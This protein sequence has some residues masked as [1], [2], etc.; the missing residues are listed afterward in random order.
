MVTSAMDIDSTV[1]LPANK[2][3]PHQWQLGQVL[4]CTN[5]DLI[6]SNGANGDSMDTDTE[7]VTHEIS[8]LAYSN[9]GE[10]V[11]AGDTLGG[12][13]VYNCSAK[14]LNRIYRRHTA[15]QSHN[16]EFDYL[17]SLEIEER[18]NH[19]TWL[20]RPN[21]SQFLLTTNDKTIK[22]W[23]IHP[24]NK[25]DRS[26][27]A[28]S[29]THSD[30][31]TT[32]KKV[33]ANAHA[34]HINSLS[35]CSDGESF[36][37]SDDLR[38]NVCMCFIMNFKFIFFFVPNFVLNIFYTC[39]TCVDMKPTDMESLSEVLT[40]AT[41]HPSQSHIFAYST[42]TGSVRLADMRTA[43]LCDNSVKEFKDASAKSSHAFFAEIL[44]CISDIKFTNAGH[45]LLMRDYMYKILYLT[46]N[47]NIFSQY[48]SLKLW[49]A[50]M[51]H[52]PVL[53][54]NVQ[55]YLRPKLKNLYLQDLIFDKYKCT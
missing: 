6:Q 5:T 49:D 23:K 1:S 29:V 36:L 35:V 11:A 22:L 41:F 51:E 25:D 40:A 28:D 34:Y 32:E 55:E 33:F 31:P 38:V 26:S 44:E 8:A 46:K 3:S 24:E 50:R 10:L 47:K 16:R 13:Y 43:A 19:L 9:C 12:V 18:I 7:S 53:T 17:R 20:P 4:A 42:S 45:Q 37:S 30:C 15:F 21:R 54:I 48:M 27:V 52:M 2:T 14:H 39:F